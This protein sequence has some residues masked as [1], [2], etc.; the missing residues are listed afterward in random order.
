MTTLNTSCFGY[1]L[2]EREDAPIV[3]GIFREMG[4]NDIDTSAVET[5]IRDIAFILMNV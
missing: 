4:E 5:G 2:R 3:Q 1:F